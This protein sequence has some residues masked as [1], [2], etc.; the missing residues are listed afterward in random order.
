MLLLADV[1]AFCDDGGASAGFSRSIFDIALLVP[2]VGATYAVAI[3][4]TA[5][6]SR[7]QNG[8]AKDKLSVDGRQIDGTE[9]LISKFVGEK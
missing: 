6:L 5:P 1:G 8:S 2:C 7:I 4:R 3:P 9:A